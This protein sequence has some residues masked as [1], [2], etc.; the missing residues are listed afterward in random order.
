MPSGIRSP[1]PPS[2]PLRKRSRK[3]NQSSAPNSDV[4]RLYDRIRLT[5]G[6]VVPR[7]NLD[8]QNSDEAY[9]DEC[10]DTRITCGAVSSVQEAAQWSGARFTGRENQVAWDRFAH[11]AII[12]WLSRGVLGQNAD[13]ASEC[14]VFADLMMA[15]RAKRFT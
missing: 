5:C 9:C 2:R 8:P 12:G 10:K 11:A 15:E 4:A 7:K 1:K 3:P 6:H 13:L 14:A